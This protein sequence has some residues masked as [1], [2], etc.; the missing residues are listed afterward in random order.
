MPY[1]LNLPEQF[2]AADYFI[3]RNV[4][5]GRA[6]KTA[7]LCEERAFT[8]GQL[9]E[10]VNRFGNALKSL[11]VRMEER[12]ALLLLD[13]E[14][15]PQAFFGA[16]K[17]GAVPICLN[18]MNRPKD[19]E[20]YLNDSRAR[21]LVVDASLLELIEPIRNNLLFVRQIIVANGEAPAGDLSLDELTADQSTHLEAA[22]TCS[23]DACF[24]LYSS[25]STGAPKGTVHLQHDMV[26]ATETYGKQVLGIKE[27]DYCFSA[28]KLFFAYGLGNGLYFPFG[29]GA[30]AIYLPKRP[31]PD[32]V[33]GT[34]HRHRPT[35]FFGVPTLYG[36]MLEAE[37]SMDNVRLCVSAG[38]ALP[39]DYINRWKDR[40][41]LDI[42]DGIGSTEMAHIFISN[43]PGDIHA[44][45]SGKVVPGY[46][47]RIVSEEM[48]DV[49]PGEIG[50]LLVK[51]DSAAAFYW[52]KHQKTRQTMMGHW[53]NTGDKYYQD[54]Q[55]YF[56]CA[57]RS[58]DMLKVGGIWVSPNEVESCLIK[59]P[60]VLECAVIGAPDENNLIKPMAFVVLKKP[61]QSATHMEAELQDFVKSS[62]AL[63][64]YPRWVRFLDE[65]PKTATGKIKRFELRNMVYSQA[66]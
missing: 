18:T 53:V 65:L 14:I 11:D 28:A 42:L 52:N 2:N 19:F 26:Y 45:S 8:Y 58:D 32:Q 20:Y 57:G 54:E 9:Q 66:A 22:S 37:G 60:A 40:F 50:T 10:N 64:K 38:E 21:V 4:R 6:N 17:I 47:A 15:Y 3:D 36:Q 24:W 56:Y 61:D 43:L 63:Y 23:D 30:T 35:L 59:H 34:I 12:V 13:T 1:N 5:E 41:D 16:I 39:G 55:G 51:G 46:E 7:V 49:A 33:Y 27:D 48:T 29:V 62:L 44:G 31:T 25:G